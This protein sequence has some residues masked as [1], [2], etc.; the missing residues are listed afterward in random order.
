[1]EK[2]RR[3]SEWQ[4]QKAGLGIQRKQLWEKEP[5][6]QNGL[7]WLILKDGQRRKTEHKCI[8]GMS[9]KPRNAR[10]VGEFLTFHASKH[11]STLSLRGPKRF[12]R[13]GFPA[14]NRTWA[15]R[16]LSRK[17]RST[18]VSAERWWCGDTE[19]SVMHLYA[20]CRKWRTE[21]SGLEGED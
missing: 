4:E 16:H 9:R 7:A 19:Q 1:M 15:D 10:V 11:G 2:D 21:R 5:G 8:P 6:Q 3:G 14:E 12:T 17:D 20:K 13:H 18:R